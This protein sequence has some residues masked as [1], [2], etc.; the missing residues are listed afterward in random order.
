MKNSPCLTDKTDLVD[1][2]DRPATADAE[3]FGQVL[4]I[5]HEYQPA[6]AKRFR[7][8]IKGSTPEGS[9]ALERDISS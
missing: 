6:A 1:G 7:I 9:F 8:F 3:K 4:N 2:F 5:E